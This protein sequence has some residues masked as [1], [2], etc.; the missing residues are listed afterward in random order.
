MIHQ[1]RQGDIYFAKLP[2]NE[3]S[4]QDG[5]RPVLVLQNNMG[6]KYSH[7]VT[8]VP[9]SSKKKSMYLPTHVVIEPDDQNH[10]HYDSV[11]LGEQIT[12]VP[13]KCLLS[14]IGTLSLEDLRRA[15]NAVLEQIKISY[16]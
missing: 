8:I 14:K 9:L 3:D 7:T 2:L 13:E 11:V 1:H 16:F 10:L 15:H 5:V 12:T 6:N 4:I